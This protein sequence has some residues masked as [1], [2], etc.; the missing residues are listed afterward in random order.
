M[1][2]TL[3]TLAVI[4]TA[5]FLEKKKKKQRPAKER[6][7]LV[8]SGNWGSAI[9]TKLGQNVLRDP[10]FEPEVRMWVF[11]EYV[12]LVESP[13]GAQWIR[14]ARGSSPPPGKTWLDAGWRPLTEVIN[15]KH[16]NVIYLPGIKLP[17]SVVAEPDIKKAVE[18]ATM[19]IF[20]IPHNFLAPIVP[21]M[22][23][24]FS[25]D[26]VGISLIKGIEFEGG[27]PI[28]ISDLLQKAMRKGVGNP[29][30][31]MSVLMGANV[32]SEVAKGDFAEA[33]IGCAD[34]EVGARWAALFDTPDFKVDAVQDVAGAELCGALKNVVALGA[35]F[36]DGLGY[37]NNTKAAI[38]RIGLKEMQRF[39]EV[40]Y[41]SRGIRAGTFLE[42]CGVAD[43][44]TTC[45]GGRNRKCAEIFARNITAGKGKP[46]EVIEAEELN[47]QKLQGTGT[48]KDVMICLR[49]QKLEDEFPLFAA[50]YRIAFESAPPASLIQINK[51]T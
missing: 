11:E 17:V 50:I 44:V 8:G 41:G 39:C 33:T 31:D 16:E 34:P 42:S 46:W 25:K 45:F 6:V 1:A 10:R 28:L 30:I 5:I 38:I 23:S 2:M 37:G 4:L 36:C 51:R 49:E 18:G 35:G 22:Q 47:G 29:T 32:A 12:K 40:F 13:G 3:T 21:R 9:A 19:M 7:V 15:E 26:A 24:A 27:K 20:V 14:P 48:A 43:L